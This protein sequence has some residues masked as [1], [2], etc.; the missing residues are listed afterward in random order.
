[1]IRGEAMINRKL[2]GNPRNKSRN[3]GFTLVELMTTVLILG[4]LSAISIPSL[5]VQLYKGRQSEAETLISQLIT[6]ASAYNDEFGKAPENWSDLDE[7]ATVPTKD[8][9]AS[10]ADF[11]DITTPSGNYSISTTQ[12][13]NKYTFIAKPKDINASKYNVVGCSNVATGASQIISG[14]SQAAA[15]TGDLKC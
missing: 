15:S 8:G 5:I 4:T 6:Q 9:A 10:T 11:A 3:I 12:S 7:I 1:M 14:N 2:E 13:N